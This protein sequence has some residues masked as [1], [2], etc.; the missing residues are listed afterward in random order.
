MDD[1]Q[2]EDLKQFIDG[3]VS[4]AETR[5]NEDLGGKIDSA[6]KRLE[7]KIKSLREKMLDGFTGVGEAIEE[8]NQRI[9]QFDTSK[10]PA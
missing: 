3:R 1:T 2:L 5:L 10:S 7:G 4:Q 8:I 9:D 6:G